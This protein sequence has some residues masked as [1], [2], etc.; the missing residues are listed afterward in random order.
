MGLIWI[1]L[2]LIESLNFVLGEA[3][4]RYRLGVISFGRF[5]LKIFDLEKSRDIEDIDFIIMWKLLKV[6]YK[7]YI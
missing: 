3:F 2:Y 5:E 6:I 1:D 7:K 4:K